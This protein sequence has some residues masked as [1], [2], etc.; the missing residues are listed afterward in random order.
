[1]PGTGSSMRRVTMGRAAPRRSRPVR[2]G[3]RTADIASKCVGAV[4]GQLAKVC[5][6]WRHI[7]PAQPSFLHRSVRW[8][9]TA[10][11]RRVPC[12]GHPVVSSACCSPYA[13]ASP[14]SEAEH[15]PN[16]G[17][18]VSFVAQGNTP[19]ASHWRSWAGL[20][21]AENGATCAHRV[22]TGATR[23]RPCSRI[24]AF[25]AHISFPNA[26]V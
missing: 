25:V 16:Q 6:V 15:F 9:S 5:L 20:S 21:A 3:P 26:F 2:P 7:A 18:C 11:G 1:M 14:T 8:A 10:P 22:V 17:Q 24:A 13:S 4:C 12:P 19:Q 23:W